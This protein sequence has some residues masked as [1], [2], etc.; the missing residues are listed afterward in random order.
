[1]KKQ[2]NREVHISAFARNKY[3]AELIQDD[4]VVFRV[5]FISLTHYF[6]MFS[7]WQH[8]K[9]WSLF[10]HN[11]NFSAKRFPNSFRYTFNDGLHKE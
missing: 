4:R 9:P 3:C 10:L 2:F 1:M 6:C 11:F 7:D 8:G 5:I